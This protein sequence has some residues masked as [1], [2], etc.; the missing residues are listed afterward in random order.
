MGDTLARWSRYKNCRELI[1]R[2]SAQIFLEITNQFTKKHSLV[3]MKIYGTH[4]KLGINI[5]FSQF[6]K[7]LNIGYS[8][9]GTFEIF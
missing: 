6:D 2:R 9:L 5:N 3:L 1:A 4:L 7:L 8:I